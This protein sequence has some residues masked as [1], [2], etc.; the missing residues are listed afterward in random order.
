[1]RRKRSDLSMHLL[2]FAKNY[3]KILL[4]ATALIVTWTS[5]SFADWRKDLGVFRIGIIESEAAKLS[6]GELDR[7][8]TAYADALA[9]PIEIIRARDFPA[10]IDAHASSRI[11][12]AIYS[13]AAYS[14]AYLLCECI[15][16]L[17]QSVGAD[18]STGTRTVLLLDASLSQA[19]MP[20]SKGIAV[21]GKN[22]LN[23]FGVPL[24]SYGAFTGRL[25]GNEEWLTFVRDTNTASK[26]YA[27]GTV[28]G[29]FA[30][31]KNTA[32]LVTAL[33]QD[34][35]LSTAIAASGRKTKAVWISNP[36]SN[37]PHAVRKNLANEAKGILSVFL[38]DLAEK[39]PDLNDILLP[40][41][42]VRFVKVAHGAYTSAITA[43]KMLAARSQ[44][45][46][47]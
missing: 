26:Q 33:Q 39:N 9:M 14:T 38:I 35:P 27:D 12:Y 8:R 31:V 20:K 23:G 45:P 34:T 10:L 16:P 43:T 4:I 7:M 37:G 22:S 29:F 46:A 18:G 15:E 24:S 5:L 2:Q 11:E 36:I 6:P 47:Q 41:N 25:T 3:V 13:A 30:T 21:P 40:A 28:D 19:Q 32:L 44:Q 1:M 42:D 17:A